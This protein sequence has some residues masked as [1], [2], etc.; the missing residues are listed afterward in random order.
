MA[1]QLDERLIKAWPREH[2]EDRKRFEKL[3]DAYIKARYSKHYHIEADDLDWLAERVEVL[4]SIVASICQ[5]RLA[6]LAAAAAH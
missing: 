1:E 5:E 3:K 2:P 4:K 6:S